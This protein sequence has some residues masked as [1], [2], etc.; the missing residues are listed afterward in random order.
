MATKIKLSTKV[1]KKK[2]TKEELEELEAQQ[3]VEIVMKEADEQNIS[4]DIV[5]SASHYAQADTIV[6]DVTPVE[7]EKT[8]M[9][10]GS[11]ALGVLALGAVGAAAGGGGGGNSSTPTT[12]TTAPTAVI[13]MSDSAILIGET[14]TVTI[15]F[16]EAVTG[17]E[18]TDF[19]A[20][21]GTLSNLSTTDNITY[22]ALFTPNTEIND[23]SNV[24]TLAANS[25]TDNT[26]NIGTVAQSGNYTVDTVSNTP[27]PS[28]T[29]PAKPTIDLNSLS[30][31]GISDTDNITND[32][33][34]TFSGTAE[35]GCTVIIKEAVNG[36]S[37]VEVGR[38]VADNNGNWE[39]TY[40]NELSSG[41]VYFMT[42]IAENG[43][44]QSEPSDILDVEID[45]VRPFTPSE[46]I[47]LN[48]V[49][50][51]GF[52]SASESTNDLYVK[53]KLSGSCVGETLVVTD[54]TTVIE[55]IVTQA[56]DDLGYVTDIAF[57]QP[58]DGEEIT[59]TAN[60]IDTAGNNGYSNS[61]SVTRDIT[62]PFVSIN[63]PQIVNNDN[64]DYVLVAGRAE[65][66]YDGQEIIIVITDANN[67]TLERSVVVENG[68]YS[69][70]FHV[71]SLQQG[72]LTVTAGLYDYAGN[73]GLM[74]RTIIYDTDMTSPYTGTSGNDVILGDTGYNTLDGRGGDDTITGGDKSDTFAFFYL[75][76]ENGT[77][78]NGID[79]ITDFT[80]NKD[81]IFDTNEDFICIKDLFAPNLIVTADNFAD[82]AQMNGNTLQID[83]DGAESTYSW[84]NLA[85]LQ[86]NT[87]TN[88]ELLNIFL[89]GQI[90][91]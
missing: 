11:I 70:I 38:V 69:N 53:I 32:T 43:A 72:D 49:N 45:N 62:A 20:Q 90:I 44:G 89:A 77:G 23:A 84:S 74:D 66:W 26:G 35:A 7:V 75:A 79:T 48:D 46:V 22:T 8:G 1:F 56:E 47:I 6:T 58:S 24:I 42:A 67:Q 91:I 17:V 18:L 55:H 5:T 61:N 68:T 86:N 39:Y 13:T 15:R 80:T 88:D 82:Y 27:P 36:F 40:S 10:A 30:D 85:V 2:L 52:L 14:S 37:A 19:V 87:I 57:S 28:V 25:Y 54:G 71:G 59:I 81:T 16:S 60:L 73:Y 63:A 31:S 51:D 76:V 21:N 29:K 78:G 34:P 33:T 65:T 50:N 3:N 83:R 4:S 64:S 12:D 41:Y 9:G